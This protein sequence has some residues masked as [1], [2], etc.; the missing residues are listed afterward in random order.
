MARH[1]RQ[2]KPRD[3]AEAPGRPCT[4]AAAP[5]A[6]MAC[7]CPRG[8]RLRTP[9]I[10]ANGIPPIPPTP[11]G[12]SGAHTPSCWPR[13]HSAPH[14]GD[15]GLARGTCSQ[16]EKSLETEEDRRCGPLPH[17]SGQPQRT[18][19]DACHL[20]RSSYEACACAHHGVWMALPGCPQTR[21]MVLKPSRT[22]CA[23]WESGK[24]PCRYD[25]VCSNGTVFFGLGVTR[26]ECGGRPPRGGSL[27][28]LGPRRPSPSAGPPQGDAAHAHPRRGGTSIVMRSLLEGKR[29]RR[30]LKHVQRLW[31]PQR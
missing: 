22:L 19:A 14:A 13:R 3:W 2:D 23:A 7:L 20:R 15:K 24:E 8:A 17:A 1:Q 9:V 11:R 21:R 10:R 16:N 12:R 28:G 26:E 29:R 25:R 30:T 31:A 6:P 5:R 18:L 27:A 4:G